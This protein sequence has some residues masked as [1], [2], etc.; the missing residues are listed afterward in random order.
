LEQLFH[1]FFQILISFLPF[2]C[3]VSEGKERRERKERKKGARKER[4]KRVR[5]REGLID[6][7]YI[8]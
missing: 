8:T 7:L 3:N 2:I 4:K 1:G 6:Y 5:V